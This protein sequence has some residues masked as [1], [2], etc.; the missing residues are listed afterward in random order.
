MMETS[1]CVVVVCDSRSLVVTCDSLELMSERQLSD[2]G[3][4]VLLSIEVDFVMVVVVADLIVSWLA[5]DSVASSVMIVVVETSCASSV[6]AAAAS[7]SM[8]M[9]A[10]LAVAVVVRAV[11]E[12]V[13]CRASIPFGNGEVG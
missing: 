6:S 5:S 7:G 2:C 13:V 1:L 11:V 10:V 8:L 4:G 3:S 12:A 9:P